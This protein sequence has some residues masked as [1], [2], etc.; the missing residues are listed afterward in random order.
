MQPDDVKMR[1]H[2]SQSLRIAVVGAG[3]AGLSAA[4]VLGRFGHQVTVFERCSDVGGVWSATRR[5]P[6]LRVQN[7]RSTYAF[8]DHP[9]PAGVA[10]W[11]TGEQVQAYLAGY[12]ERFGLAERLRLGTEVIA[13]ELDET[14]GKWTLQSVRV[15]SGAVATE[16][17]DHLVVANGVFSEP[18]VPAFAGAEQHAAAGGRVL[19][20][21]QLPGL[22]AARD[23]DVIVVGYGK[24]ACDVAEAVSEVAAS[25]TVVARRLRWKM[26]RRV[27]G[28]NYKYLLLTRLGEALFRHPGSRR[29]QRLLHGRYVRLASRMLGAVQ[30][31]ATRQDRLRQLG[32]L[33]PG[34]FGELANSTGSLTTDRFFAKVRRGRIVVHRDAEIARLLSD[35][36]RP[37]AELTDGALVPAALVLCGTGY[38]Q[39]VPFL[40]EPL[41]RRLTDGRGNFALYRHILPLD[42][43]HLTFA[44]YNSSFF[45]PLS[46]EIAALWTAHLLTGELQL[47]PTDK[48]RA[49]VHA[50]LR[51]MQAR[52]DGKHARGTNIIP[53]SMHN[54]DELLNDVGLDISPAARLRQW[55]LPIDPRAYRSIEQRLLARQRARAVRA[56]APAP[57]TA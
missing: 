55:L 18:F 28:L 30:A 57:A 54:I 46:A 36:G 45:S 51:W 11:P 47:P 23:R 4:K 32:L 56:V 24:S 16:V 8:S 13:A 29:P 15:E 41:Q 38:D 17:F 25:T 9:W 42:V 43:P 12:V 3:F 48:M 7:V 40:S 26:P 2:N 31:V 44:G 21:T 5:Y 52:T 53:F 19:H 27:A 33:P 39:R 6:G 22:E 35:G 49:Q 1:H 10:E 34:T 20:S 37:L 14:A 50:R